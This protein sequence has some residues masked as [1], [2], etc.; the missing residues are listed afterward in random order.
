MHDD[1][2]NFPLPK[3]NKP[4]QPIRSD[5]RALETE[6]RKSRDKD[7]IPFAPT[8]NSLRKK[9]NDSFSLF[10]SFILILIRLLPYSL[11]IMSEC[12]SSRREPFFLIITITSLLHSKPPFHPFPSN[13]WLGAGF[14]TTRVPEK[15][16]RFIL[17]LSCFTS[18]ST[19]FSR[20]HRCSSLTR[21]QG[22]CR[23]QAPHHPCPD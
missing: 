16:Y 8:V 21:Q 18:N 2:I 3:G 20:C 9:T 15:M 6:R 14:L 22:H 1:L 12:K 7:A 5:S 23:L 10:P 17:T 19:C 13:C 11:S 4:L